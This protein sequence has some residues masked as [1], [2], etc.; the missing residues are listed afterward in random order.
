MAGYINAT[1]NQKMKL[2]NNGINLENDEKKTANKVE[3]ALTYYLKY[4]ACLL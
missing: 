2:L 1:T 3:M 4:T